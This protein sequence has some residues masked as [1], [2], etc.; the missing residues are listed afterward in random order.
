MWHWRS[1]N[2]KETEMPQRD[3]GKSAIVS[4]YPATRAARL[5][6]FFAFRVA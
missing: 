2:V 1:L 3:D 5:G 6:R 4:V